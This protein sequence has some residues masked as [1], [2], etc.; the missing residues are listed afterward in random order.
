MKALLL[1]SGTGSRMG[2]LTSSQPKCM[3]DI[4]FGYTIIS[5]QLELLKRNG[6]GE[7][8]V[9]TGPFASM[10]EE[11]ILAHGS[12]IKFIFVSNP[13]Y[14]E[15]NYIYSM[16]LAKDYLDDDIL[17]LHGDI[18]MAP[19]V[20]TDLISENR[21]VVTVDSLAP[22]PDKDFKAKLDNGKV[23]AIGIE[24]FGEDCVSCQPAYKLL[25]T[26]FKTWMDEIVELCHRGETRVYAEKA[27]NN[28]SNKISLY[29]LDLSTRLCNEIDNINDL[30]LISGL[31]KKNYDGWG[32]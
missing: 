12:D 26:D 14:S 18:V 11:Y 4:G 9:T 7:A 15:T 31:F 30:E 22:L 8:V 5:W 32:L 1:N 19:D 27:L 6:I 29:P 25:Y 17:L 28:I 20:L 2:T 13:I 16:Y 3:C 21:S 10:L 23:K 24:F